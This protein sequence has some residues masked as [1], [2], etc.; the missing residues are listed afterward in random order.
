M[1]IKR[2]HIHLY[3][4]NQ[5]SCSIGI[6]NL[7]DSGTAAD[8]N[9][10]ILELQGHSGLNVSLQG[11]SKKRARFPILNWEVRALIDFLSLRDLLEKV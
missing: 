4:W 1:E 8:Q 9:C 7:N 5:Q 10:E 11:L 6:S 3:C 2:F